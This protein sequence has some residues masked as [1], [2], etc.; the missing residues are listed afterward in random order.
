MKIEIDH[1]EA[2]DEEASGAI[3]HAESCGTR[4]SRGAKLS[5][6]SKS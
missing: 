3:H 4:Q 1:L 6:E 5:P 2:S